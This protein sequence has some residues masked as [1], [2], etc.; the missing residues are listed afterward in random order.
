MI[1]GLMTYSNDKFSFFLYEFRSKNNYNS[2]QL[3]KQV[4]YVIASDEISLADIVAIY[5]KKEALPDTK[6]IPFPQADN[7]ERIVDLLGLLYETDL[8]KDEITSNYEFDPRQTQYYTAAGR[9]LG[10]IDKYSDGVTKE[11]TY[12]LTDIGRAILGKSYKAKYLALAEKIM[13]HAVFRDVFSLCLDKSDVIDISDIKV[14]MQDQLDY[15]SYTLERRA[16]TVRGW[17]YWIF[18]LR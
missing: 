11:T 16:R 3:I 13:E 5:E 6:G 9:Y 10:L 4:D 8:T 14:I 15:S 1:N 17:I 7:F 18:S 2:L 12:S